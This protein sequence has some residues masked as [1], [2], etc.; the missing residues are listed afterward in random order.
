[1]RVA[2]VLL[3]LLALSVVGYRLWLG[4]QAP[5]D[6]IRWRIE[7]AVEGFNDER[8]SP[9]VDLLGP[10]FAEESSGFHRSDVRRAL[11]AAFFREV[12]PKTGD[13]LLHAAVE[14]LAIDV[15]GET[16]RVSCVVRLAR[17]AGAGG[18]SEDVWV[19]ELEGDL[20]ED[21][22]GW[23]FTRAKFRTLDGRIPR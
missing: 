20:A 14:D 22:V 11:V 13:F 5:E 7:D 6:R 9:C 3:S 12:D 1:V 23:R 10:G 17:R 2:L 8:A 18:A 15:A 21:D 16:A 4:Q 19:F